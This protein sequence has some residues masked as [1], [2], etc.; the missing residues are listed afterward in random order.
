MKTSVSGQ[1]SKSH[2]RY[3]FMMHMNKMTMWPHVAR[4]AFLL[5]PHKRADDR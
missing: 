5:L 3:S 1:F 4:G 2:K